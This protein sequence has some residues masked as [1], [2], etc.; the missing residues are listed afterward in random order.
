MLKINQVQKKRFDDLAAFGFY[1]STLHRNAE[2]SKDAAF[3]RGNRGFFWRALDQHYASHNRRTPIDFVEQQIMENEILLSN[4]EGELN[5][6]EANN[7]HPRHHSLKLG[8]FSKL[9]QI[10]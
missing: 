3:L 10:N 6:D 5:R 9:S 4:L 1:V 8:K 7:L 2:F